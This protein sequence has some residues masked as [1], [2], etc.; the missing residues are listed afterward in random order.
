MSES[1]SFSVQVG[2]DVTGH[3]VVGDGNVVRSGPATAQRDAAPGR[4]LRAVPR[5]VVVVDVEGSGRLPGARQRLMREDLRSAVREGVAAL[6]A[7][8]DDL[9]PADLGD[10]VRLVLAPETASPAD[11]LDLF[12]PA[13]GRALRVAAR[14]RLRIAVHFGFADRSGG[15]WSG[16][17]LVHAAR[18]V[19]AAEVKALLAGDDAAVLALVVSDPLHH[20]LLAQSYGESGYRRVDVVVKET[21]ARAWVR[22]H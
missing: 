11:V 19:D 15:Q 14:L 12:V 4:E 16:Q 7:R 10:G 13:V 17:P 1:R 2:G 8:W 21:S 20:D 3:V 18:L 6:G 9:A 22:L 5:T